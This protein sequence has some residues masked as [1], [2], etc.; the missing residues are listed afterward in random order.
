MSYRAGQVWSYAAPAG[1]EDS[2]MTIGAI[3]SFEDGE[4]VVCCSVEQAPQRMPDGRVGTTAIPFLPMSEQ[5]FA[6]SVVALDGEGLAPPEFA[7][8]Y[9]EWKTDPKGLSCFSV[10]FEGFLDRMI[11]LQMAEIV[12]A[13]VAD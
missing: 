8:A 5:A 1:F 7:D 12:G 11:A 10:P 2:R 4:R 3:I 9:D 6:Q 13:D